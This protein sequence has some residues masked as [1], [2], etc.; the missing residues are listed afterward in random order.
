MNGERREVLRQGARLLVL[1]A[2]AAK[3]W[4]AVLA[5][6]PEQAA[7]VR[8]AIE[9]GGRDQIGP[10]LE[11][12]ESTGALAYTLRVAREQADRAIATL[13][14]VPDSPYKEALRALAEFSVR[15]TH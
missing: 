1:T 4:P 11:A 12:I 5:G 13:E 6:T 9:E 3:A 8:R 14:G 10:I 15:R 7:L 2:A